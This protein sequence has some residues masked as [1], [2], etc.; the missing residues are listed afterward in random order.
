MDLGIMVN[1]FPFV[2]PK[3]IRRNLPVHAVKKYL[4]TYE[5]ALSAV[6]FAK[7]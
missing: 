5:L 7:Q 1:T 4:P 3:L 6:S 2:L